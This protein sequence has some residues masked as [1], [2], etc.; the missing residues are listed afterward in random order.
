M[1][2]IKKIIAGVTALLVVSS[3]GLTAYAAEKEEVVYVMTDAGG[4]VSGVYV[5][6]SFNGGEITDYGDYSDVKLM[7]INGT[8]NQ[9]GDKIT[10]TSAENQ[11][12]YYQGTIENAE[13]PWNISIKYFLDGEE[14]SPEEIA[15]KSGAL[16][17]K[18]KISENKSCKSD[19]FKNYALQCSFTLD[20]AI[21][22]SISA[23]GA[24]AA[25]VGSDKQLTYTILPGK[26]IDRSIKADVTD[27]EMPAASINGIRM[28]LGIDVDGK[29]LEKKFNDLIDGTSELDDGANE[30][31][32]GGKELKDGS[33]DLKSGIEKLRDGIDTAQS[34][35]DTLY[36][37]SSDL[38]DGSYE[39]KS[40]LL[41][42]QSSLSSVSANTDKLEELCAASV[43]IKEG[44]GS[45]S[46]GISQLKSSLS[47]DA[48]K[49][50]LSANGLDVDT[51]KAGNE[52]AILMLGEQIANLEATVSQIESIPEYAD[53]AAQLNEQITQLE[54]VITLLS[55][56]SAALGG[57][58][59]YFDSVSQAAEQLEAGAYEL[60]EKYEEF[61][62]AIG[63]LAD[64]LKGILVN[65]SALS[66]GIDTL[67]SEYSKFDSGLSE[68]ADGISELYSGFNDLSDGSRELAK[69]SKTLADGTTELVEGAAELSKGT[70]KLRDGT[71]DMESKVSD[72]LGD[73]LN[74]MT[75]DDYEPVSFAS[76]KNKDIKS[77]QFVI[78]TDAIEIPE[79]EEPEKEPEKEQG[80]VQK[81]LN[82]FK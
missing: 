74:A 60:Q 37:K 29:D 81:F 34:G 8:I 6:N 19:F 78:K 64:T 28:D 40:A 4:S 43:Q 82:L 33:S 20:T 45:L 69:G 24:T 23:E 14:Y 57:T 72:E 42:I 36:D 12:V 22:K 1:N 56:N 71:S 10:F 18:V 32:D 51:L 44:I 47:Y 52:Q 3:C 48:Y 11:K 27:F 53:Q 70:G 9:D 16:E 77:V 79:E 58:E 55:G 50:A 80:F 35:V 17:I 63:E 25:N 5:V 7:N 66:D 59:T 26:G 30:L 15:G 41:T 46:S 49:S 76:D 68:Y 73:T 13:I 2:N 54:N 39:V 21:C 31:Y 62:K 75:S 38:T 65:I 61:D 67:V